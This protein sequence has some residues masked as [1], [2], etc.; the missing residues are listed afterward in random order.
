MFDRDWYHRLCSPFG[1]WTPRRKGEQLTHCRENSSARHWMEDLEFD[2]SPLGEQSSHWRNVLAMHKVNQIGPSFTC[3][4]SIHMH[5][6]DR[7][8]K[9]LW[10]ARQR[11][12]LELLDRWVQNSYNMFWKSRRSDS[13]L[14]YTLEMWKLHWC[15]R[16]HIISSQFLSKNNQFHL[17]PGLEQTYIWLV[18][19]M[20]KL[21]DSYWCERYN[22]RKLAI[23]FLAFTNC[24]Q[25]DTCRRLPL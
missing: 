13:S 14:V 22:M 12:T 5:T 10:Q 7:K 24:S 16:D 2:H 4:S 15:L 17:L 9:R 20:S 1:N 25:S 21:C 6:P 19:C 23:L 18:Q 8:L 3:L 11:H